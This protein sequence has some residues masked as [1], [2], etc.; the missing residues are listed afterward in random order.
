M[1]EKRVQGTRTNYF[2]QLLNVDGEREAEIS[3]LGVEM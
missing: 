1:E 3:E 2:E